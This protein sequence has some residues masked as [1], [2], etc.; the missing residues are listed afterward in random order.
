MNKDGK[1]IDK[2]GNLLEPDSLDDDFAQHEIIGG[3]SPPEPTREEL[4]Q[5]RRREADMELHKIAE[6]R[7]IEN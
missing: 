3:A 6:A 7:F 1:L 4:E 2:D 5:M